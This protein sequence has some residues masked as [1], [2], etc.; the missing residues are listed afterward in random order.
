MTKH[1]ATCWMSSTQREAF[2]TLFSRLSPARSDRWCDLLC[3]KPEKW[4]K[5]K[6]WQ[7]WPDG[8]IER[9]YP[10]QMTSQQMIEY[11]LAYAKQRGVL[12]VHGL[13]CG[14]SS[15]EVVSLHLAE[16]PEWWLHLNEGF[17]SIEAGRMALIVNHEGGNWLWQ[18]SMN[19]LEG[20][21]C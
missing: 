8:Y 18:S 7:S 16:A 15:P 20:K 17:M 4:A 1:E 12:V 6:P 3:G 5:I 10:K 13:A 19:E 11:A 2:E 14:H 9:N 21:K